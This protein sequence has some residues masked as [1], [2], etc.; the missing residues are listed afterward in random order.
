MENAWISADFQ[1]NISNVSHYFKLISLL[2]WP[3]SKQLTFQIHVTI[4]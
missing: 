1:P 4:V 2:S 3:L